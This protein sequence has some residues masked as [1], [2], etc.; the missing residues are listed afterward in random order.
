MKQQISALMDKVLTKGMSMM[1]SERAQAILSS[2]Q[3]QKAMDLGMAALGKMQEASD[4]FKAGVAT[5][6]GLATQKEVDDLREEIAR[7]S[8]ERAAQTESQEEA[9]E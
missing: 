2:P 3:A 6:L 9:K 5:K 1:E 8:A 4:C 7:L